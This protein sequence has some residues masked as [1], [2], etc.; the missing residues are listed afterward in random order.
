MLNYVLI[1]KKKFLLLLVLTGFLW[2]ND[3]ILL[4]V[5]FYGPANMFAFAES[6]KGEHHHNNIPKKN[7]SISNSH[8]Q[9][10]Q[11]RASYKKITH[12]QKTTS[13]IKQ[14][15]KITHV[16]KTTSSIKQTKMIA[17]HST[18]KGEHKNKILNIH[19]MN[20]HID[21]NNEKNTFDNITMAGDESI[22][23][24][25]NKYEDEKGV[26]PINHIT[27][28]NSSNE[29]DPENS[30]ASSEI[31]LFGGSPP[32][33]AAV[34]LA[35]D[36]DLATIQEAEKAGLQVYRYLKL[37]HLGITVA[38]IRIPS[39]SDENK[40]RTWFQEKGAYNIMRNTYYEL[41]EIEDITYSNA[42]SYALN[43]ITWPH[44]CPPCHN[45]I[46]I[47]MIDSYVDTEV[48]VLVDRN[49]VKQTFIQNA[50]DNDVD[51]GTAIAS[52]LVG[53]CNSHFCGM[54]PSATL[55]AATA[56][57][58]TKGANA[59]STVLA[60]IEALDWLVG[61]DVQVINLSFSGPDN[62]LLKI[63]IEKTIDLKISIVAAAGNYGKESP[64]AYPAA[65]PGV[66]A[67]TAIDK[68]RRSYRKANQG[69]YISF[70]E[71]GVRVLVPGKGNKL[72][73]KTGTSFAAAYCTA[74]IANLLNHN[75]I[76]RNIKLVITQLKKDAE[77]LGIPGKDPVFGWGLARCGNLC[78]SNYK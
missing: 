7:S 17:H 61:K 47:G 35:V 19:K 41:D 34:L 59:R 40:V 72:Y 42:T 37:K 9:T 69:D 30:D 10:K 4:C 8:R 63:C 22:D 21:S 73:Y 51:H 65:Y 44:S 43:M 12:V 16:Q 78:R 6:N 62:N 28:Y 32:H 15:K 29:Q 64:P 76:N 50:I 58:K 25:D 3:C 67:V 48:N 52:I 26:K 45:D 60:V 39:S 23:N 14:T 33:E 71:P 24:I 54:L 70:A 13:N 18:Q 77:D 1:V 57:N 27:D 36:V 56:F 11:P 38:K 31:S 66:I 20:T 55:F 74:L 53:E 49:I 46:R 2:G 5:D 75:N 68:F